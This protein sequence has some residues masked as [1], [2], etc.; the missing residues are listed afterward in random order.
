MSNNSLSFYDPDP[1]EL[2]RVSLVG[3]LTGLTFKLSDD[4][5]KKQNPT[6]SNPVP[7]QNPLG[8]GF[9]NPL[10]LDIP[11]PLGLNF[12]NPIPSSRPNENR[13][14]K[15]KVLGNE[16]RKPKQQENPPNSNPVLNPNPLGLN[17]P[18]PIPSSRPNENRNRK[19]KQQE[20]P[21]PGQ[22]PSKFPQPGQKG[23]VQCSI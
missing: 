7:N 12:P 6:N 21:P 23:T 1:D 11:N 10:G 13:N 14:R 19:P 8:L 5:K 3:I 9:P 22:A 17:F 2:L 15:P 16:N 18:N 20:N 4:A